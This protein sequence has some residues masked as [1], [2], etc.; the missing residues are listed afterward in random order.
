MQ[1]RLAE[2]H[3]DG[4]CCVCSLGSNATY[5]LERFLLFVLEPRFAQW[6]QCVCSSAFFVEL[7]LPVEAVALYNIG[8]EEQSF[9][10]SFD[11]FVP[12]G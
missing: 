7:R 12:F 3:V 5:S 11:C 9:L 10:M 2:R 6:V 4:M 8:S 1:K